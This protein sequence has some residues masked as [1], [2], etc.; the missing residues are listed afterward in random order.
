MAKRIFSNT[1]HFWICDSLIEAAMPDHTVRTYNR[2]GDVVEDF[3]ISEV[4]PLTYD[5]NE[6][7]YNTAK[8]YD[9]QYNDEDENT[10]V[11]SESSVLH[12]KQAVA[13]CRSYQAEHG[14]HGLM[15]P[16]GHTII[17]PSYSL[18]TA[19]VGPDLYLCKVA[20][21]RKLILNGKGQ[22]VK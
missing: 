18:I 12:F 4:E 19:I 14:W 7:Y 5:T 1:F 21:G 20:D 9:Y 10:V 8:N 3:Y 15:S 11:E 2:K 16:E 6:V 17:P 22:R 13:R